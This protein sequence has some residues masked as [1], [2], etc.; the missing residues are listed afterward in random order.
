[1]RYFFHNN[2]HFR[3]PRF[4]GLV[5]SILLFSAL[6]IRAQTETELSILPDSTFTD[7]RDNATYRTVAIGTQVWMAENLNFNTTSGSWCYN[8]NSDTCK[9]FGRLY[10]MDAALRACP[11]GWHLPN[12]VEWNTLFIHTIDKQGTKLRA[13]DRWQDAGIGTDEFGFAALPGG[14][15]NFNEGEFNYAG[16]YG[17][18]WTSD[19]SDALGAWSQYLSYE[20]DVFFQLV[21]NKKD[22][23]S[24]RCVKNM[25]PVEKSQQKR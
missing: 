22:G 25:T 3:F 8:N 15:R 4:F 21:S 7:P 16:Y 20:H 14:F 10:N 6:S 18:W 23:F 12:R 2:K 11:K 17:F 9:L 19:E 24:V 13:K 1:M 5:A